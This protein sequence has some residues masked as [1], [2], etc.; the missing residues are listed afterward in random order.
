MLRSLSSRGIRQAPAIRSHL[1]VIGFLA[2][3]LSLS[4]SAS[5]EIVVGDGRAASCTELAL[6]NALAS[7]QIDGGGTIRFQCGAAPVTIDL[8]AVGEDLR[9]TV[10]YPLPPAALNPPDHTTIDGGG[11]VTLQ[12]N[13]PFSTVVHIAAGRKVRLT[14]LVVTGGNVGVFNEGTLALSDS[15]VRDNA[16]H[17][18]LYLTSGIFNDGA[19]TVKNSTFL[20]N[21]NYASSP[22]GGIFNWGTLTVDH[23]AFSGGRSGISGGIGNWGTLDIR[24]SV[25]TDNFGELAGGIGNIRGDATIKNV[26]FSRNYSLLSGGIFNGA[27]LTLENSTFL[28][29]FAGELPASGAIYNVSPTVTTIRNCEF[30]GN[31]GTWAGAIA[32]HSPLI[33]SNSTFSG[34]HGYFYGGAIYT[35]DA[36][37]VRHS[38]VTENTAGINGAGI[39]ADPGIS[40][41][42]IHT[43]VTNNTPTDIIVHP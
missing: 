36:L 7:A 15:I 6:R 39:Y 29:N 38:R 20:R 5:A 8:I 19:L 11:L 13:A 18:L 37:T 23:S 31:Q 14:G 1:S 27:S 17:Y 34:N 35:D 9:T 30:F 2:V 10:G 4:V 32:N 16:E 3:T 26:D 12:G 43:S 28:D 25:I 22:A 21:G 33:V 42:L 41:I 24:N 40:P